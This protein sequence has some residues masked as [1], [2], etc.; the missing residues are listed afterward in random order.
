MTDVNNEQFWVEQG[1]QNPR[2]KGTV[3]YRFFGAHSNLPAAT[4]EAKQLSLARVL[5]VS[6]VA[7]YQD[8]K[9]ISTAEDK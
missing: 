4:T 6:L 3:G 5:K 8:G 9:K 2:E 1:M 7:I